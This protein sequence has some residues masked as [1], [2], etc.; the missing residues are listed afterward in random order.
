MASIDN[1]PDNYLS[2]SYGVG[3]TPSP[4]F[5]IANQFLPRNL[6]DVIRWARYITIQSPVTTEVIR[7]LATYPITDFIVDSKNDSVKDKY[8]AVFKSF[9]LKQAL[10]DIG[11]D[12]YTV[13]NVFV[14]IYFPI[15]RSL[16]CPQCKV[17][18]NAKKASFLKF[19]QYQFKGV[20]PECNFDGVFQRKDTKSLDVADMNLVKWNPQ[21]IAVNHNP[22]TGE[23][24]YYYTIPNEIRNK[25]QRGD[26][27]FVDSVPWEF[28]DAVRYNQ[29]FKFDGG[30]IFHL[31]N[32][33]TG[34]MVEGLSVPPLI[35]LFT[36]VFYQATLR[37]ANEAI[38]T[39]HM[40]PLRVVFPQVQGGTDPLVSMSLKNFS[41]NMKQA[42]KMHK[43]DQN[44]F[45]VAPMP[46]GYQTIGGDGKNLLVAQE[47]AQAEESIL[48]S[49][50][51]SKELLSGTTNW[52]SST[53]GLRMLEN[54]LLS[55]TGQLSELITWVMSKT[56]S[57]LNIEPVGV[58]LAPFKLTD[59]DSLKQI[60]M[61]L[62]ESGGASMSTLY[63]ALGMDYDKELDR[64]KGDMVAKAANDVET[65]FE[66]EQAQFMASKKVGDKMD[67]S[68]G[69]QNL[70]REAQAAVQQLQSMDDN[71]RRATLIQLKAENYPLFLMATTMLQEISQGINPGQDPDTA[72]PPPSGD[73]GQDQGQQDDSENSAPSPAGNAQDQSA[74]SK[75]SGKPS[76]KKAQTTSND[77]G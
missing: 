12:Y 65:K 35:S 48:L 77:K 6:H 29:N 44:H 26:R 3:Q 40:T 18:Y 54:T 66:V 59:D 71:S 62:M 45:L 5:T 53:V 64:M 39:E 13:G 27:L 1:L 23:S 25:V 47:I 21:H 76:S 31:R 42:I 58:T 7:K 74:P 49:L 14:S 52:T 36:L 15:H 24:E 37:R 63:E 20:C 56:S 70:L 43:K 28:I 30:S 33:S 46:V 17:S 68:N 67:D 16:I 69:Y 34:H 4:W 11:F 8:K 22:I 73:D 2:A 57:Y 10:Q 51:V 41:L 32:V 55:Y 38:A 9:K 19:H 75:G 61:N 60:L 72:Q 50:G